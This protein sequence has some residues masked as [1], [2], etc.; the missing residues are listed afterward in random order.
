MLDI[1]GQRCGELLRGRLTG[2][3]SVD[4]KRAEA[5]NLYSS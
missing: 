2:E 1:S 3:G 4:G 5:E